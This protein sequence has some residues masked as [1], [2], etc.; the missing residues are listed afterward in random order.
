MT[1]KQF[2]EKQ[3]DS[4]ITEYYTSKNMYVFMEDYARLKMIEENK[5]ILAMA[6]RH[7]DARAVLVIEQRIF[8]L[9]NQSTALNIAEGSCSRNKPYDNKNMKS[10]ILQILLEESTTLYNPDGKNE[11]VINSDEF[12]TVANQVIYIFNEK[13]KEKDDEILKYRTALDSLRETF[14]DEFITSILKL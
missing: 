1:A 7:M 2:V 5:S 14:N 9:E 11:T 3:A 6:E 13:I 12:E 4:Y 10:E 8:D